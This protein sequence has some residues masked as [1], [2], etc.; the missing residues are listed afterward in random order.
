MMKALT[1][2]TE[3]SL[4]AG[5]PQGR[6]PDFFIV[7]HPK[8]GTTALYEMLTHHPEIYL[9]DSKEPWLFAEELHDRPPPRPE[10]TPKTLADYL[11]WFDAARPEQRVGEPRN[12]IGE[13]F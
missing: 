11:S 7:G 8:S 6:V 9:P 12:V 5:A 2:S 3:S 10:G 13:A 4:A 1:M